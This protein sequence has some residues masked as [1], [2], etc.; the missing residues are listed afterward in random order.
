MFG[1]SRRDGQPLGQGGELRGAGLLL[2]G[3]DPEHLLVL[4][5]QYEALA[6]CYRAAGIQVSD[7]PGPDESVDARRAGIPGWSPQAE[8]IRRV[9]VDTATRAE[10]ACGI[11]TPEEIM[12]AN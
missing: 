11:P 3:D 10:R 2:P 7:P 1:L 9:G 12:S 8:A 5:A 6:E 4:Y